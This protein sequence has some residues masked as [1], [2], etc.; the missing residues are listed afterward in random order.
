MALCLFRCA[1]GELGL[2]GWAGLADA[3]PLICVKRYFRGGWYR[4]AAVMVASPMWVGGSGTL[5]TGTLFISASPAFPPVVVCDPIR[6]S[7][8]INV[9]LHHDFGCLQQ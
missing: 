3:A 7:A 6:V 8:V 2:S 4:G 5:P 1:A 9:A